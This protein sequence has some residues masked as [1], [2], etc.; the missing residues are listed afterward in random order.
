M[1]GCVRYMGGTIKCNLNAESRRVGLYT[2]GIPYIP[3]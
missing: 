3:T 1:S 2:D